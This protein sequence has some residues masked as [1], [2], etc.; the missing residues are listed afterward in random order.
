MQDSSISR[1]HRQ[2][3]RPQTA[4]VLGAG[5]SRPAGLP[6][7]G[8]LFDPPPRELLGWTNFPAREVPEAFR[9]WSLAHPDLTAEQFIGH[10]YKNPFMFELPGEYFPY[11]PAFD[12]QLQLPEPP[13]SPTERWPIRWPTL[14]EYVQLRL[15]WPLEPFR[16]WSE[17]RYKPQML[18]APRCGAQT[19]F[20][21]HCLDRY[22]L[23]GVVT[24]NYDLTPEQALGVKPSAASP[25]F[26]YGALNCSFHPAN[27]PFPKERHSYRGPGGLVPVSKLHGSLNWSLESGG[28]IVYC[29]LR[30]AFRRGGTAALVPPLPEKDVPRWLELVWDQAFATLSNVDVWIV[31]GYSL[32]AYDTEVRRLF[33][34]ASHD[35]H[36]AIY[37]P[38]AERVA[39]AFAEV[40]PTASFELHAGLAEDRH[41]RR[42][43]RRT[44]LVQKR[45]GNRGD[46]WGGK[47]SNLRPTDYE[48]SWKPSIEQNLA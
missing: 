31:A 14:V 41:D 7:A 22:E 15:A 19:S 2:S 29:D 35:Q 36:I 18:R 4:L 16:S 26:N 38:S 40:C 3:S 23:A 1:R 47:D 28:L 25:G 20:L 33:S 30:A 27:S 12:A 8:E 43:R 6:L 42:P 13:E 11:H 48:S 46:I 24:T 37:D 9:Q 21:A 44:P 45:Q 32:P 39:S 5:W 17:L 10:V 34:A